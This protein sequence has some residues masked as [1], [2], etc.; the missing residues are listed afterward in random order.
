[1]YAGLCGD[2]LKKLPF[3]GEIQTTS[4]QEKTRLVEQHEKSVSAKL[5]FKTSY[6]KRRK[7]Y[8]DNL[9]RCSELVSS[10]SS[11]SMEENQFRDKIISNLGQL[12]QEIKTLVE[13]SFLEE[14]TLVGNIASQ[15]RYQILLENHR[16][17]TDD[18][19]FDYEIILR[20]IDSVDKMRHYLSPEE[21]IGPL[22]HLAQPQTSLNDGAMGSTEENL[23]QVIESEKVHKILY[24]YLHGNGD[25][26]AF[27]NFA[28]CGPAGVGKSSLAESLREFVGL[29]F[30]FEKPGSIPPVVWSVEQVETIG[31][32]NIFL[33]SLG[34][35]C[36][37]DEAYGFL[38]YKDAR[39]S[40]VTLID[41]QEKFRQC[42][43][44][45]YVMYTRDQLKRFSVINQ[46]FVRRLMSVLDLE[47]LS[48]SAITWFIIKKLKESG[49]TLD[50]W[51]SKQLYDSVEYLK[52][53]GVS[54]N[55]NFSF[56]NNLTAALLAL[57]KGPAGLSAET[58]HGAAMLYYGTN[59][60]EPQ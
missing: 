59:L 42:S 7:T 21:S 55:Q 57:A 48:A 3:L 37:F 11:V 49:V 53:R 19:A 45:I 40:L 15:D 27:L 34:H 44:L 32:E 60:L 20:T 54:E 36:V 6:L 39:G 12:I 31:M 10:Y 52:S 13:R 5:V 22:P 18:P 25:Q 50:R 14:S 43:S 58:I 4:E 51:N 29:L 16:K 26:S 9:V 23:T 47:N 56:V 24:E 1:M 2:F 35:C 38:E 17:L 30:L 28:I 46:G 33:L 8:L 41:L